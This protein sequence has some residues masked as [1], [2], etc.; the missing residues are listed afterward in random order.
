MD[1]VIPSAME[2]LGLR[3]APAPF[4][5]AVPDT[6]LMARSLMWLFVAGAA[7]TLGS[8]CALSKAARFATCVSG[9][10]GAFS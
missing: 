6:G 5:R 1:R 2:R 3:S 8:G 9:S 10:F 4:P 7:I